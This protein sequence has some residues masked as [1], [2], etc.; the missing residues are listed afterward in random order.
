MN[1]FKRDKPGAMPPV[2]P[3]QPRRVLV[4]GSTGHPRVRCVRWDERTFPNVADYEAVIVN[5]APL[6]QI[7]QNLPADESNEFC[8][9]LSENQ[10]LVRAGLLKALG[11][12]APVYAIDS[13]EFRRPSV[14]GDGVPYF[15]GMTNREWVPIPVRQ[16]R[17]EGETVV[18]VDADYRVYCGLVSRWDHVYFI[19]Q[20]EQQQWTWVLHEMFGRK[21]D[22]YVVIQHEPVAANCYHRMVA[23]K[24]RLAFH[25]IVYDRYG[26]RGVSQ[27]PERRSGDLILLPQPTDVSDRDA[28]NVLLE[29]FFGIPRE[30]MPPEWTGEV[31]LPGEEAL[32]KED[33]KHAASVQELSEKRE[34]IAKGI[35]DLREYKRLLYETGPA[36][37][38]ICKRVLSELGA[39]VREAEVAQEDFVVEW[40]GL[41][42]VVEV[43]GHTR[44]VRVDDLRQLGHYRDEY[45]IK[46]GKEIKGILLGNAWRLEH[47]GRRTGRQE[48]TQ[49]AIEYATSRGIKIG[50]A[51]V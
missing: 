15:G 23:V 16:E 39:S 38:A 13:A 30:S 35:W 24:L 36:L 46:N 3:A 21:L 47:P 5:S 29:S 41:K 9:R 1:L 10:R 2:V 45:R 28:V 43:K 25:G 22:S 49:D 44:T 40:N 31:R 14:R 33:E 6:A 20:M 18:V 50:R 37:E 42:A 34:R 26:G 48:F 4:V 11:A 51:H 8:Q 27:E 17:E 19:Q 7:I 12:G 32:I